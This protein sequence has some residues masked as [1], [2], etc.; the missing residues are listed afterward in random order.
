MKKN[1][2]DYFYFY[3]KT[4]KVILVYSICTGPL[5]TFHVLSIYFHDEKQKET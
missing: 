3:N 4:T 2:N 1:Y 5:M